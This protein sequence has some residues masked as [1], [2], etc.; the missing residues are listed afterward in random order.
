MI[1]VRSE[2]PT[3][4]LFPEELSVSFEGFGSDAFDTLQSI[5]EAPH[6]E[7]YRSLKKVIEPSIIQPFKRFR[8]DL[9]VNWVLPNMLPFE[10]ERN[11]FSRLLKNDFG[12]GGCHHHLWLS[13]YRVGL[14]RLKDIQIAHTLRESGFSTS[15]FLGENA[16][17]LF[18][19]VKAQIH[20][21]PGAF[22]EL[23]NRLLQR[24]GWAFRVR[25]H[26]AMHGEYLEYKSEL[27]T[28][29]GEIGRAK[30]M[31]WTTFSPKESILNQ[32]GP[33]LEKSILAI[34]D[35]WPL[36]LLLLDKPHR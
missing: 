25:P 15:L 12:A 31:W 6:I 33:L 9:A 11:V 1:P 14:R 21:N 26:K 19:A 34:R 16:P 17:S 10:T 30:G 18:N 2:F 29:P 7:T 22:L 13:F 24:E 20:A 27:A 3:E 28:I 32:G 5:K 8:D 35:L 36:Y 4:L 23:V